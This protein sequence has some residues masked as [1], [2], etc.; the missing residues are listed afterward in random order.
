M[1]QTFAKVAVL[2][3]FIVGLGVW[4]YAH[5]YKLPPAPHFSTRIAVEKYE[6]ARANLYD[7]AL[8]LCLQASNNGAY[9]WENW[10][11][12]ENKQAILNNRVPSLEVLLDAIAEMDKDGCL[13][14]SFDEVL[15]NYDKA[16]YEYQKLIEQ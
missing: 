14:D 2:V 8:T 4:I 15:Y 9:V 10:V 12:E 5:S 11:S 13:C 6:I 7:A 3:T 1:K 16:Y